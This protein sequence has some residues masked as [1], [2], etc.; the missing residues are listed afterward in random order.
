MMEVP[1]LGRLRRIKK[2]LFS[3]SRNP[4]FSQHP[5]RLFGSFVKNPS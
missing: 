2:Q 4:L 3:M 5:L 1:E